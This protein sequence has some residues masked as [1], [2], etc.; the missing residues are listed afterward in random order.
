MAAPG[1]ERQADQLRDD[2]AAQEG[3]AHQAGLRVRYDLPFVILCGYPCISIAEH[4]VEAIFVVRLV[5]EADSD[6]GGDCEVTDNVMMRLRS[7]V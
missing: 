2:D 3:Q 5:L 1:A 4:L 7:I 6:C